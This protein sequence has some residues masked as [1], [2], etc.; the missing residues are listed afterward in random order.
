[1]DFYIAKFDYKQRFFCGGEVALFLPFFLAMLFIIP[2]LKIKLPEIMEN[3][4]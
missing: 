2:T 4:I 3:T 1:M